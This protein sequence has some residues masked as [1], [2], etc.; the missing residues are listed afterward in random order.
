MRTVVVRP[1]RTG[2]LAAI[3]A[4]YNDAIETTTGTFDTE[5][6]TEVAQKKWFASHNAR[7][8]ILVA[9]M[10]DEVAGWVSLSAW[11]DRAAYDD[12]AELS[13]YV[14]ADVRGRG[15][16][17]QLMEGILAAGVAQ[18]LHVIIARVT[19]GNPVSIRL[20]DAFGF[21]RIGIMR[22]VGRKFGKRL[23]VHLYQ[24]ILN[25]DA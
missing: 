16:G 8:P 19:E 22:E 25:P 14:R 11:S 21:E 2:D 1:A 17:R 20:H 9:E 24:K 3:T 4:I 23:D 15:I 5:P 7:H 18:G 13:M 12:T 10:R 6:R